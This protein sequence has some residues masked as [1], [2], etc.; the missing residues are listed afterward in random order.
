M[1]LAHYCLSAMQPLAQ[2]LTPWFRLTASPFAILLY[3]TPLSDMDAAVG[4]WR[5]AHYI[6]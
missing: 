4:F 3:V 2:C 5:G 6:N 1:T